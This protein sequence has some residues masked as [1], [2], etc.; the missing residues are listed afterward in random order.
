MNTKDILK[1][2]KDANF[3]QILAYMVE[4]IVEYNASNYVMACKK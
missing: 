2:V 3:L 1:I 4:E